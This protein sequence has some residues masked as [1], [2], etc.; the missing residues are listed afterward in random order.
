MKL[1]TCTKVEDMMSVDLEGISSQ[2][3]SKSNKLLAETTL[4]HLKQK[5]GQILKLDDAIGAKIKAAQE[6]E[7]KITNADTYQATL[8]ERIA[9]LSEFIRKAGM[10]PL[11]LQLP[12]LSM[13]AVIPP[14][15]IL[16]LPETSG[17]PAT[18]QLR[19][20]T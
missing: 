12:P 2:T 11:E 9:F 18:P 1:I 15:S 3:V 6:F 19:Q 7:E 5:K 10:P 17:C 20:H 4:A 8:D 14:P 16:P 13:T